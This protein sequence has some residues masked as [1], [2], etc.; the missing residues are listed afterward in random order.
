MSD[1]ARFEDGQRPGRR[2][3]F[4]ILNERLD[5]DRFR[6]LHRSSSQATWWMPAGGPAPC[7]GAPTG[8]ICPHRGRFNPQARM[9]RRREP[10][11]APT[12]LRILDRQFAP[13]DPDD[14]LPWNG[15]LVD[16]AARPVPG[17]QVRFQ[18][19]GPL[20]TAE[21]LVDRTWAIPVEPSP[22]QPVGELVAVPGCLGQDQEQ[23]RAG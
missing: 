13:P 17:R 5:W 4:G 10:V 18:E 8:P 11:Y 9:A 21:V 6:I 19:L 3:R 15:D 1:G 2:P 16:P 7:A 20:E 22:S 12:W 14:R 23:A